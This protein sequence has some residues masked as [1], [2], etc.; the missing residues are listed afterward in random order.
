MNNYII[1]KY[2]KF[3]KSENLNDLIQINK[4]YELNKIYFSKSDEILKRINYIYNYQKIKN[5]KYMRKKIISNILN[6]G[7]KT[8]LREYYFS[9]NLTPFNINKLLFNQ[10]KKLSKKKSSLKK[11]N[12][13]NNKNRLNSTLLSNFK[14]KD[15]PINLSPQIRHNQSCFICEINTLSDLKYAFDK[16]YISRFGKTIL[17]WNK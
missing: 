1:N 16:D 5:K 13:F 9:I 14:K 6:Y 4:Q 7:I 2:L 10:T 17:K 3:K 12:S 11:E 8:F 15:S